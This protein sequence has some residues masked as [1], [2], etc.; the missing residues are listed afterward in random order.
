MGSF[1]NK[2]VLLQWKSLRK[3]LGAEYTPVR[4]FSSV[5]FGA[6]NWVKMIVLAVCEYFPIV[7]HFWH[8]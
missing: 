8:P 4:N 2:V 5:R 7:S 1:V 3:P 6:S